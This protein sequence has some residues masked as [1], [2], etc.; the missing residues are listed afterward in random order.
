MAKI[1]K[2]KKSNRGAEVR[3]GKCGKVINPGEYYFKAEPYMAPAITRCESCGLK[4]YETSSSSYVQSMGELTSDWQSSYSTESSAASDIADY[5]EEIKSELEDNFDNIPE[6]LQDGSAGQ[7]LQ[8]RI[9]CLEDVISNLQDL[10]YDDVYE[11]ARYE[12]SSEMGDPDDFD[13]DDEDFKEYE[14]KEAF[15]EEFNEAVDQRAA[16]MWEYNIQEVLDQIEY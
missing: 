14:S 9:D 8:E 12:V 5:L 2:I 4:S 10:D 16:E 3:C 13:L 11:D 1:Q 6:Q 15:E 7:L